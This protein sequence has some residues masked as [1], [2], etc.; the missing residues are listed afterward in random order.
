MANVWLERLEHMDNVPRN[1]INENRNYNFNYEMYDE[2][3]FRGRFRLTKD[4][5]REML[6]II[7]VDISAHNEQGNPI[8]ADIKLFLTLRYYATGTF[9]QASADL[10]EISQLSASCIIKRISEAIARLKQNY[11]QFPAVDMLR[12]IKLDF[13]RICAFPNVVET[14]DCTHIKIPCPGGENAELFRNRKGFFSVNVQAVSGP[15]LEIQHIVVR[16][17]D[18]VHDS[19]IFENSRLCAQFEH[20]D[21]QGMLLDDNGYPCR[22]Y[23]MTPLLDPQTTP[24]R[25]YNASHIRTRNTV[26]R[27]FGAWKRLFPCL[28]MSI[29]TKLSTTLT[30]IVATA[31]PYNFVRGRSYP[32]E[33]EHL[34]DHD[35]NPLP[36]MNDLARPFG[37]ATRRALIIQHFTLIFVLVTA[38]HFISVLNVLHVCITI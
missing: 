37:N 7:E 36:A 4:G 30:F 23:L 20:G 10:C 14:I 15:N 2:D 22:S 32:I 35:E 29:R 9:Q 25:K 11:I 17:P 26:E 33:E 27:I 18:S 31:V 13:M 16:W 3:Q 5:F 28:S 19:R 6:I 34:E 1:N 38:T 21:I 24:V 8:P 12:Q